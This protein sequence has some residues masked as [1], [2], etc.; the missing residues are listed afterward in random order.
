MVSTR[1]GTGNVVA[2]PD[3]RG[4]VAAVLAEQVSLPTGGG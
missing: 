1:Y 2:T 3:G 4:V